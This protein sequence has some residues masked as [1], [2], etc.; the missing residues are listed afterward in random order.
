MANW[1]ITNYVIKGNEEEIAELNSIFTK[2]SNDESHDQNWLGNIAVEMG[3]STNDVYCRGW[4][5]NVKLDNK[6]TLRMETETAWNPCFQLFDF[7]HKRFPS[8]NYFFKAIEPGCEV[9][10]TNDKE[11]LYF[12]YGSKY[13]VLDEKD[14]EKSIIAERFISNLISK[15]MAKTLINQKN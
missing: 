9:Y 7:I 1:C 6:K 12:K 11:K 4:F 8:I 14:I 13:R 15:D 3:L 2:Y 10:L 5:W